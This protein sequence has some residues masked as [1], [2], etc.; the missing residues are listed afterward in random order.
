MLAD[1]FER[2][3]STKRCVL[4]MAVYFYGQGIKINLIFTTLEDKQP[5]GREIERMRGVELIF[6]VLLFLL[7]FFFFLF[8][9]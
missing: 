8:F 9:I 2:F 1:V 5:L 4:F 7:L 6:F 3:I